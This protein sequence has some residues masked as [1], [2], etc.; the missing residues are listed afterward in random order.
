VEYFLTETQREILA[1]TREI[2]EREIVPVRS[3]LDE[4]EIFPREIVR[5]LGEAGLM[6]IFV[7]EEYGG[8]GSS[9]MDLCLV[10]EE[11]SRALLYA[12]APSIDGGSR[13][14]AMESSMAKVVASDAAMSVT[15]EAVQAFG[16]YGYMRNYPVEKMLRDAKILQI[17]EGTNQIQKNEIA[18]ALIKRAARTN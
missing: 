10:T 7:P 1:L 14:F 2:A 12:V 3:K 15:V 13:D 16:G 17:Y 18:Q 5:T 4:E 9:M 11:L 8:V 6:G